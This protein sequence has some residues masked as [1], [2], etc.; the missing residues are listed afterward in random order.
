MG[1]SFSSHTIKSQCSSRSHYHHQSLSRFFPKREWFA[2]FYNFHEKNRQ[3]RDLKRNKRLTQ[4]S[5]T[6]FSYFSKFSKLFKQRISDWKFQWKF[7]F[8]RQ[9]IKH[10]FLK[11]NQ[12]H[13]ITEN[14][15]LVSAGE[16]ELFS[17][18]VFINFIICNGQQEE[19]SALRPQWA[20]KF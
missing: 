15:E 14:C 12:F 19:K 5:T 17:S 9:R 1:K 6:E 7:S 16:A 3:S 20:G 18:I 10:G 11:M 2:K 8:I 4:A 13:K